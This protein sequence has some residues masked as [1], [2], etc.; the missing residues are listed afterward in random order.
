MSFLLRLAP[1]FVAV[2]AL[3]CQVGF[4]CG[5]VPCPP[6]TAYVGSPCGFKSFTS[7]C[8][9]FH[10]A[11]SIECGA[12]GCSV[13]LKGTSGETCTVAVVY[14]DGTSAA[15]TLTFAAEASDGCCPGVHEMRET[16]M[17]MA[18]LTCV[19][20]GGVDSAVDASTDASNG[21]ADASPD[22]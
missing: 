15:T 7:T 22:Q 16:P 12:T 11:Q 18:P 19:S 20:D 9:G 14:G 8:S 1:G 13:A 3:G 6:D 21:D 2:G 5:T 17:L 10:G 4:T